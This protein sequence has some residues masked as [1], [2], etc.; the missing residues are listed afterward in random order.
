M[1][2]LLVALAIVLLIATQ[3]LAGPG[4]SWRAAGRSWRNSGSQLFD[5][6]G[7]SIGDD[8]NKKQEWREVGQEFEDAGKNTGGALRDTV[9]PDDNRGSKSK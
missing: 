1:K 7:K 3:C 8:A 9:T 4:S 2:T 5:A 6:I